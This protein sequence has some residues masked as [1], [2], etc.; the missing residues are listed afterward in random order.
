M[1]LWVFIVYWTTLAVASIVEAHRAV[2]SFVVPNL[3]AASTSS[4]KYIW[5][6]FTIAI[7]VM[8]LPEA[9]L[10]NRTRWMTRLC[11]LGLIIAAG[12]TALGLVGWLSLLLRETTIPAAAYF[13]SQAG[14]WWLAAWYCWSVMLGHAR[15]FPNE[16]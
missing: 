2:L 10:F 4:S 12:W 14:G 5:V 9:I 3:P 8:I 7:P 13:V 16:D 6:V 1:S 15:R 11:R